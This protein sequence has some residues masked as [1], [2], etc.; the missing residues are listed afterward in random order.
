ME[1]LEERQKQMFGMTVE[2]IKEAID[3]TLIYNRDTRMMVMSMISDIQEN[4]TSEADR[5][6]LNVIKYI[7][8]TTL[9]GA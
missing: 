7:I 6:K 4:I 9:K 5:K 2:E 1:N 3:H 8:D